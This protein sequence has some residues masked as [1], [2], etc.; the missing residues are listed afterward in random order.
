M[1]LDL[2]SKS[3]AL[4]GARLSSQDDEFDYRIFEF[5]KAMAPGEDRRFTFRT[6][7]G[8]GA[9]A[10]PGKIPGWCETAP[11]STISKSRPS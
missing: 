4:E 2:E 1:D 10:I 3:I 8:S 9:S 7:A 5:A 11:S 6:S